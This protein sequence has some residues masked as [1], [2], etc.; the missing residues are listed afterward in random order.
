MSFNGGGG[1]PGG[2]LGV[3]SFSVRWT[4]QVLAPANGTYNFMTTSD[5]GVRLWVDN[6]LLINKWFDRGAPATPDTATIFLEGGKRYDIRIEYYKNGGAALIDLMWSGPG[7]A[8]QTIPTAQL[9]PPETDTIFLDALYPSI[10]RSTITRRSWLVLAS[11]D[12]DELYEVAAIVNDSRKNFNLTGKATRVTLKGENLLEKFNS[13]VRETVIYAASEELTI[14]EAPDTSA[15]PQGSHAITVQSKVSG[16]AKGRELIVVG[17]DASSGAPIAEMVLLERL[18]QN[19]T[20]LVFQSDL[21]NSYKRD[22]TVIQA[23]VAAA[24]HGETKIEVP[25]S[26]DASQ[27]FQ[28]FVLKQAPLTYTATDQTPSG[29]ITTLAVRVNDVLW[30][31]TPSL[32]GLSQRDRDYITRLDDDGKITV[33]FGDGQSGAR[34]PTGAR[35]SRPPIEWAPASRVWSKQI[36]SAC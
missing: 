23:N 32:Y 24:T 25:G 33:M 17:L 8:Q 2:G 35:T 27:S 31:E 9:F 36:R 16:L 6:R 1:S 30:A 15:I 22:G 28:K 11:P 12:Y 7:I 21:I 14:A 29:S 3:D 4:G 5:D 13:A 26:G 20:R 10:A 18:E 34:L 19:G